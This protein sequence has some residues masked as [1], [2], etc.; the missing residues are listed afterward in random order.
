MKIDIIKLIHQLLPTAKRQDGRKGVL[1]AL[2]D[3]GEVWDVYY[4]WQLRIKRILCASSQK[5]KLQRYLRDAFG[6]E[7]IFIKDGHSGKLVVVRRSEKL[8]NELIFGL[9]EQQEQIQ[10]LQLEEETSSNADYTVVA[11]SEIDNA[12]LK[13]E[14][15]RFNPATKKFMIK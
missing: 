6:R 12:M 7:D 2:I 11:I 4:K 8:N 10:F 13:A 5:I 9:R 1:T 3:L 15:E 14:V